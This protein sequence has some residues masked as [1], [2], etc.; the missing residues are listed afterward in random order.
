MKKLLLICLVLLLSGCVD[1][2]IL[3]DINIEVGVGYDLA[4]DPKDKY[5][6]TILFQEFQPDKSVINRTFSGNGK[7]RQDLIIDV[8]RQSSEP[9]VTGGLKV[10][11]FG[12]KIS[13]LGIY[14]LIDSFQ[15]DPSI[16]ARVF[17]ITS[18]DKAEDLLK[19][20]YGTRGNSTYIYNLIQH[21]IEHRDIPKTNLHLAFRNYHERGRD[22]FLP[23]L[24]KIANDKVELIGISLFEK[25]KEVDI[26]P[27][28]DLFFFKLL[29]DKY[30][31][32]NFDVQLKKGDLAAIKSI[33][34]THKIKITD[35]HAAININIE[36]IVREYT[37][38][39]LTTAVVKDVEKKLEKKV[40]REC[41]KLLKKFQELGV[42]PVGLGQIKKTQH[43]NFDYKKW[44]DD[45]KT[46][47]FEVKC[48]VNIEETGII[49]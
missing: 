3:D 49:E 36:G 32:G 33:K 37:G 28:E 1:K 6:G 11:V 47:G 17:V 16:G 10:A 27:L 2:E 7:L 15:R 26:L 48:N 22:M 43:R 23:R 35:N 44:E 40:E 5:R 42:D 30:S 39:K 9:V 31:E 45:Y 8:T 12:P 20:E 41:L 29:V 46:L 24:K 38:T 18:E 19:G 14:D 25:D 4:E 13:K 21:N 34:S